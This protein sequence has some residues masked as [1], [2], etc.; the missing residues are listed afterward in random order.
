MFCERK[1]MKTLMLILVLA[2]ISPML[3]LGRAVSVL[4]MEDLIGGAKIVLVGKALSVEPSGITTTMGYPSWRGATFEWLKVEVEVLEPVKGVEK[5]DHVRTLMLSNSGQGPMFNPPGMVEPE[6]GRAYL[7]CLL[8]T[9]ISNVYASLTAP[10]DDDQA[11][12]LLDRKPW[13]RLTYHK[14]GKK[15]AFH[16]QSER[17]AVLWNLVDNDGR[18]QPGTVAEMQRTYLEEIRMIP[19]TNA[20]IHL[21]WETWKSASGWE[22]DVP[23]GYSNR[24]ATTS[25]PI[26]M[27]AEGKK[28]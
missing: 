27:P 24:T 3:A 10:W 8:P 5:G 7:L 18:I 1:M 15:V 12:F 11:I 6:K 23:K 21:Q 4:D 16:E 14:E 20:V 19:D 9:T 28:K 13:S 2:A 26:T 22:W 25:S 17:N